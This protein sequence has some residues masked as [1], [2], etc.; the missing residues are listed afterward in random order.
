MLRTGL[1]YVIAA[2]AEIGGCYAV[3]MVLKHDASSLWLGLAALLL[4][5]FAWF[6]SRID[7]DFAGRAFAAY[8]GVYV[9]ASLVWLWLAEQQAPSRADLLGVA[10]VLAGAVVIVVGNPQARLP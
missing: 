8:G 5:S 9:A 7:Q 1:L 3:W 4:G 6:L 10:L 2:F